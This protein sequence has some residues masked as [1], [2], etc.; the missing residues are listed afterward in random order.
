MLRAAL[1]PQHAVL[2]VPGGSLEGGCRA[3]GVFLLFYFNF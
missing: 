2:H 1:L 3:I